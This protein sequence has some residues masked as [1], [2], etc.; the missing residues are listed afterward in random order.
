M[1]TL[2]LFLVLLFPFEA[3]AFHP[4][5]PWVARTNLLFTCD[6]TTGTL[7]TDCGTFTRASNGW[8][9]D[10]T[11]ALQVASTNVPRFDYD[12]STHAIKG[13][14]IEDSRQNL[15]L[16]SQSPATQSITT[17][18]QSYAIS[19]Y[20]T[21]SIALTGTIT[22][23]VTGSGANVLTSYSTT[24]SA[25]TLTCTV[26]GSV[27][28]AQVEAGTF[29]TS[30]IVTAGSPVTRAQ[31]D[32]V[33]TSASWINPQAGTTETEFSVEGFNAT[34]NASGHIYKDSSNFVGPYVS[35][36][37]FNTHIDNAT[38]FYYGTNLAGAVANTVYKVA[39]A[40]KTGANQGAANGSLITDSNLTSATVPAGLKNV[41]L[42][43]RISGGSNT[44]NG[45]LRKFQYWN[46]NLSSAV[47]QAITS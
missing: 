14:L 38:T 19:F 5:G 39:M 41:S 30:R 42:G 11:G 21:G 29:A 1:K 36:N 13:L 37:V 16:N 43:N 9:F 25:G 35:S 6:F 33:I 17:T 47:L 7:S 34:W 10:N 20:G 40:Y 18:A 31:D 15:F 23:T 8:Y 27:T 32:L 3:K 44:L 12:P 2:A 28:N 46:T 45:W 26:S 4:F 22:H 24:A